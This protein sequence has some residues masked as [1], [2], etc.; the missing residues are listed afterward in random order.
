MADRKLLGARSHGRTPLGTPSISERRMAARQRGDRKFDPGVDCVNGHTSLRWT[1]NG[2]CIDCKRARDNAYN[3]AHPAE[4]LAR[5]RKSAAARPSAVK[6]YQRLYYAAH[7]SAIKKRTR[8]WAVAHPEHVRTRARAWCRKH[9]DRL[10]ARTRALYAMNPAPSR[11]SKRRWKQAN[12]AK[13]RAADSLRRAKEI[14]A[15]TGCRKSYALFVAA[16]RSAPSIPCYWC[17][18]KTKVGR[19]HLDHIIPLAK[20]GADTI[21]NLCVAC[22][23]CNLRKSAKLPEE[24]AGQ[25]ELRFA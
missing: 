17:R 22:P 11:E 25:S 7:T 3:A 2:I 19:R 10:N 5:S 8:A 4:H 13:V 21:G 18:T 24:F 6:A 23:P 16:M 15:A 9:R 14:G 1:N 20:G 12:P